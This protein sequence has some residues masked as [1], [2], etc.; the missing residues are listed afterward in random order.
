MFTTIYPF[1]GRI[2]RIIPLLQIQQ[3]HAGCESPPAL[4]PGAVP[5]DVGVSSPP[6]SLLTEGTEGGASPLCPTGAQAFYCTLVLPLLDC[7]AAVTLTCKMKEVFQ[8]ILRQKSAHVQHRSHTCLVFYNIKYLQTIIA[9]DL[10][11]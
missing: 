10:I 7:V 5:W 3:S 2:L 11:I 1:R 9:Q 6:L 4:F 8:T